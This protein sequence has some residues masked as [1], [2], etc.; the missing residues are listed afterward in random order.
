[1]WNAA[2]HR[3]DVR[4]GLT[5]PSVMTSSMGLCS[6]PLGVKITHL[7]IV[8]TSANIHEG[9]DGFKACIGQEGG[10]EGGD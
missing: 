8:P 2:E 3:G 4:E 10:T 5:E 9:N 6:G 7:H 1:M